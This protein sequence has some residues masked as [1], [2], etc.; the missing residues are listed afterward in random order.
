MTARVDTTHKEKH[1]TDQVKPIGDAKPA[2]EVKAPEVV[3]IGSNPVQ[4]PEVVVAP[5]KAL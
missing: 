4:A 5:A 2:T 3:T 1:M